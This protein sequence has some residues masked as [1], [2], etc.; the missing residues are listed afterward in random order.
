MTA[1]AVNAIANSPYWSQSAIII[2]YDETDG[3]Y[4]HVPPTMRSTFADGTILSAGPRIPN[5]VISPFAA[6]GTISHQYSEH[7]SII[8]FINELKGLVP[9]AKLPDE[10]RGRAMG[11]AN[12]GQDNLEP[13]D[14]PEN[15]VGDLTE[16]FDYDRLAG[17]KA[18]IP[19][20]A[21]TFTP[22]QVH[23]LP[24][25][26]KASYS[27]NGYTNGACEAIG[28]LPTDFKN[29]EDYRKGMPTDPYPADFNPRPTQSPG[30][31]TMGNWTP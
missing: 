16:A 5:I 10:M 24:H 1:D 15:G 3:L 31:P 4:D 8:K 25:M 29:I 2:T 27:P 19:A 28:V 13:S 14:D 22:S 6:G 17:R 9:L 21:A 7:G 26:A 11:K 18:P 20:S 23:T 30:T 12:L